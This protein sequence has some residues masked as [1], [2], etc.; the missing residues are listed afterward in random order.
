MVYSKSKEIQ[1][2]VRDLVTR[3]WHFVPGKKHGKIIAPNGRKMPVPCT[4]SDWRAVHNFRSHL[5]RACYS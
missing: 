1:K 5:K 2:L 3:G 4:P